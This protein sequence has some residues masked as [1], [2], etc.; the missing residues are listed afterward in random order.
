MKQG[1]KNNVKLNLHWVNFGYE[2]LP[3]PSQRKLAVPSALH[4]G[5]PKSFQ[6]GSA[7]VDPAVPFCPDV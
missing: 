4:L 2:L 3:V 7:E 5:I 6:V 1:V